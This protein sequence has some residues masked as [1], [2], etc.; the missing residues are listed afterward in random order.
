MTHI[1]V[2]TIFKKSN[3]ITI[4][5]LHLPPLPGY[6]GFPGFEVA[7]KNAI[8]DAQALEKGGADA[9]IFENNYD[10]PHTMD[11][12]E[13]VVN[14]MI[15]I[16]IEIKAN[17]TVPLGVSVL[18]NDYRAALRIAKAVGG[19]FIRV[20]VFVDKV[21]TAYGYTEGTPE[22]V[23]ACRKELHCE[24]IALFTDIH[25]KHSEVLTG[26]PIIVTAKRA[27]AAGA[28][29]LI[30]TGKWTGDAPDVT[31][32]KEVRDAVVDFPIFCGSG[33][34]EKNIMKLYTYANGSI[35]STSI[36][37]DS[38]ITHEINLKPYDVRISEEKTRNLCI[39]T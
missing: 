35:V 12:S 32:I 6:E 16:G 24:H 33:V 27:I 4:G 3:A 23:I 18:W 17:T 36:K 30:I 22:D 1:A 20:P 29:A 13:E 15:T 2:E 21:Q 14:A 10:L 11:V 34:D 9:I 7:I 37:E 25:V 5:A 39:S 38:E 28:D 26:E 19:T 31:E 8:F